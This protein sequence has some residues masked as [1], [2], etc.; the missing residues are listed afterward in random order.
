VHGIR[1][2]PEKSGLWLRRT[3]I[4]D[5]PR[6][7]DF[8]EHGVDYL[9]L[10]WGIVLNHYFALVDEKVWGVGLDSER[11]AAFWGAAQRE[12]AT[13]LSLVAQGTEFLLKAEICQVSPWLLVSRDPGDWPKGCEKGDVQYSEF[14][15]IDAKDLVKVYNTFADC[16][17]PEDFAGIFGSLRHQ[18]N[19]TMHSVERGLRHVPKPILETILIVS[20]HLIGTRRWSL[21]R[22]NF[23]H[24]DRYS[25]L[26]PEG[27]EEAVI[28]ELLL[29]TNLLTNSQTTRFFGFNKK[30]RRYGCPT[31]SQVSMRLAIQCRTAQL[32]P[33][34]PDS[35]EIFCFTCD[36]TISV[37]R[38]RC[39]HGD[40]K[41]N[42]ILSE[43]GECL[44]CWR[45]C[46]Q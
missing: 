45:R 23:V 36:K 18:R 9:N 29:V 35:S 34:T 17:L 37:V 31:C 4:T 10:G 19:S 15:T 12:L 42:V 39:S 6:S 40:C 13:A 5:I 22:R 8:R 43:T 25:V 21:E 46:G 2:L 44:T 3:M 7:S 11:E 30:Q 38:S 33:N 1:Q 26:N 32:T 16:R 27:R 20:E 14:R 28:G 41:G 24:R